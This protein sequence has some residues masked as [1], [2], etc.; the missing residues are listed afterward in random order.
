MGKPVLS[1]AAIGIA[2][3]VLWKLAAFIFLPIL[4]LLFKIALIGGLILA[5]YW[6]FNKRGKTDKPPE[7]PPVSE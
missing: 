3:F 1:L 5:A 7:S 2:G 6:W 4:F